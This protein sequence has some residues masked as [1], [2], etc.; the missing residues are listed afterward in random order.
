M[1]RILEGWLAAPKHW[2]AFYIAFPLSLFL[3]L[4]AAG[5]PIRGADGVCMG[6][7]DCFRDLGLGKAEGAQ[8]R[9]ARPLP[10]GLAPLVLSGESW[11]FVPRPEGP[12][13]PP[14]GSVGLRPTPHS[15]EGVGRFARSRTRMVGVWGFH[16][17]ESR[18]GPVGF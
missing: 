9:A 3:L 12:P 15:P 14:S 6:L 8:A 4:S 17:H 10:A 11:R 16:P 1:Q 7:D 13:T 18:G 2:K 5:S